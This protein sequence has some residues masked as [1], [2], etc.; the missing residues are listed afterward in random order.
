M[1]NYLFAALAALTISEVMIVRAEASIEGNVH[2]SV[3]P[4]V[5]DW[6]DS[7]TAVVLGGAS[8]IN[9]AH[10]IL[11]GATATTPG[12]V[13]AARVGA[14]I[15]GAGGAIWIMRNKPFTRRALNPES[16]N[17]NLEKAREK[18]ER[19][20]NKAKDALENAATAARKKTADALDSAAKKV[21]P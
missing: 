21:N 20:I 9:I 14:S 4:S 19:N 12:G 8:A 3:E 11:S 5:T 6:R 10:L 7:T 13:I 1:K 17:R 2:I 18:A 16:I 15:L